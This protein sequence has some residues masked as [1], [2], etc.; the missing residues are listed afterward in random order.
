MPDRQT[1]RPADRARPAPDRESPTHPNN[2][3]P[4]RPDGGDPGTPDEAARPA[5]RRGWKERLD[6]LGGRLRGLGDRLRGAADLPEAEDGERAGAQS[7]RR[8]LGNADIGFGH[9][10]AAL[11]REASTLAQRAA[12][13]HLPRVDV[14]YEEVEEEA[15]LAARCRAVFH[16]WVERVRTNVQDA[17]QGSAR[18]AGSHLSAYEHE[19]GGLEGA[20]AELEQ[21]A[22]ALHQAEEAAEA[23]QSQV[24]VRGFFAHW[25]YWI[26]IPLLVLVDWVANVPV[27][28]E[29]LPS[30]PGADE[31]WRELVARSEQYGLWA[32]AYRMAARTLHSIDASLLALGVIVFLVFLAHH[33]GEALRR[34]VSLSSRDT[35]TAATAVRSHRRQFFWSALLSFVGL[36]GVIAFL[37][38]ARNRLETS[39]A[40]RLADARAQVEAAATRLEGAR[41]A[42][43]LTAVGQAQQELQVAETLYEQRF[44]RA[45]Y[46]EVIAVMNGPILLLN[47]VLALAAAL[48]AFLVTRD[49]VRGLLESPRA[50]ALRARVQELKAATEARRAALAGLEAD[51]QREFAYS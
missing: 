24:E 34:V 47:I 23:G 1:A 2:T 35:P 33:F 12:A 45:Q 27:F 13:A 46:A 49:S 18:D 17:V 41:A 6:G 10:L 3:A 51:V 31:A 42:D 39:T 22:P 30:D 9:D 16:G 29:L 25:K 20:V 44:E 26:L 50:A 11:E 15:H 38:L 7:L 40:E 19:L 8:I 28:T 21:T 4:P 43:D 48:A 36:V 14:V 5:P 37:F 32:G